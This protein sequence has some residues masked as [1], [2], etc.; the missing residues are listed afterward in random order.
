MYYIYLQRYMYR[1]TG[2]LQINH[3]QKLTS[4][5]NK[6][7]S[8]YHRTHSEYVT[9]RGIFTNKIAAFTIPTCNYTSHAEKQDSDDNIT[10]QCSTSTYMYV[11]VKN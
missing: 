5:R 10:I 3:L 11:V 9:M 4:N 6:I 1:A 2:Q 7:N 8:D